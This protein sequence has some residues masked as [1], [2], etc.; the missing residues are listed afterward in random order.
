MK[1]KN[2]EI[3][4][5]ALLNDQMGNIKDLEVSFKE[6]KESLSYED[7]E[8]IKQAVLEQAKHS[9]CEHSDVLAVSLCKAIVLINQF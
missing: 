7:K 2:Y 9:N 1:S 5:L 6:E 4:K 8:L 3:A